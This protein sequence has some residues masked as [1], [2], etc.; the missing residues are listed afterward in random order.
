[1]FFGIESGAP[2]FADEA[3]G[4]AYW[5]QREKLHRAVLAGKA[6]AAALRARRDALEATWIAEEEKLLADATPDTTALAEFAARAAAQE[7]ALVDEFSREDWAEMPG[8]GH[9]AQ[10]WRKHNAALGQPRR[11]AE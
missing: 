9:F 5:L 1:M 2:V 6:D 11:Y 4:R 10:Y 8:G 7:Q 3:Q